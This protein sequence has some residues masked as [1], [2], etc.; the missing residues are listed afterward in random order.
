MADVRGLMTIVVV[1][2][3]GAVQ[4]TNPPR[5]VGQ[6]KQSGAN[7]IKVVSNDKGTVHTVLTVNILYEN[8]IL[9]LFFCRASLYYAL[10]STLLWNIDDMLNLE[11]KIPNTVTVNRDV[12]MFFLQFRLGK[13]ISRLR[14]LIVPILGKNLVVVTFVMDNLI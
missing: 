4:A 3:I 12:A 2:V 11:K 10:S 5:T 9:S 13:S 7:A 6:G 14:G 1:L 8:Q